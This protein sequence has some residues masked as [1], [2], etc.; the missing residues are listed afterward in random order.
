M[1]PDM[2]KLRA[3]FRPPRN[4]LIFFVLVV[5]VPAATLIALGLRLLDQDRA[6]ARQRQLELLDHAAD[7]GVRSLE[8]DIA[9]RMKRLAAAP[10]TP[11]DVLDDAV[12]VVLHADGIEAFPPNRIPYYPRNERLQEPPPGPF[13]E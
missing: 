3:W 9:A 7:Q 1:T 13:E 11:A 8:Q 10:C 4:L 5:G 12:C 2:S 6:L